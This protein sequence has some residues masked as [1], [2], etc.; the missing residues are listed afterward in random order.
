MGEELDF[1]WAMQPRGFAYDQCRLTNHSMHEQWLQI[2][3]K[4]ITKD[5]PAGFAKVSIEQAQPQSY[6]CRRVAHPRED[7]GPHVRSMYH[8]ASTTITEGIRKAK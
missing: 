2:L 4:D 3:L 5:V 7:E 8:D 1:Q 6:T